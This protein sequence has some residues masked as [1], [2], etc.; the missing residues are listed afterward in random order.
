VI[1]VRLASSLEEVGLDATHWNRLAACGSTNTVFQTHQWASSWMAAFGQDHA[2]L[3]LSAS[4][5]QGV[6]ALAA[7]VARRRQPRVLRFLGE[8]RADYC[9]LLADPRQPEAATALLRALLA[10]S[11]WDVIEFNNVPERSQTPE[12][13]RATCAHG[14]YRLLTSHQYVC[15]TLLIEGHEDSAQRIREKASLKRREKY[16]RRRGRLVCRHLTRQADIE[17]YLE[18]FFAQHISRW[19]GRSPSLFLD[20]SNRTFYRELVRQLSPEGW[21]LFSIVELDDQPIAFHFGFDYCGSVL[22]YKP[23]F[24]PL[25]AAGSPGLVL[26]RELISYAVV[27]GRHELDFTVGAEPFKA[28]FTNAARRTVGLRVYRSNARFAAACAGH[29]L[30][31]GWK[32]LR[33]HTAGGA[34]SNPGSALA[35]LG[36][37]GTR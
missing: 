11:S 33:R 15:P 5:S 3:F 9:D 7:L 6:A 30:L 23:S 21:L 12:M 22:W 37:G 19:A 35:A 27:N 24:E 13:V 2:T 29:L 14:G 34:R 4:N 28:R 31:R 17:V 18:R 1:E 8:G 32:H 20:D 36:P 10:D 26:V 25:H 16:F